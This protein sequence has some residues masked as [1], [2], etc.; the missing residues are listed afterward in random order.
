MKTSKTRFW[1]SIVSGVL[2]VSAGV[3]FLLANLGIISLNWEVIVGP[4]FGIGGLVFLFI[5]IKN[6]DSW[7]ALIPAFV[8]IAIGIIIFMDNQLPAEAQR[9]SGAVFLGLLSLA[10]LLIYVFHRENWW[11]IIPG[12]VLL[13][14]AVVNLV[15]ENDLLSGGVF[16]LGMAV[17][18]G[19]LYALP[20]PS[21]KQ[22]WALYPAGVL[23]L[24]G[25]LVTLGSVNILQ[26]VW[27]IGLLAAGGYFIYRSIKK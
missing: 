26:Y 23:F 20:N 21:G 25:V 15:S 24:V 10:F 4:L 18:F 14:L 7:W 11:A 1:L 13:T 9:W 22:K 19:L 8:L 16:F 12:G 17:T 6:K 3:F 5:F 27:P 2:L